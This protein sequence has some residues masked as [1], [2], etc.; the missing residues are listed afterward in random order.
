MC[1]WP[2]GLGLL[3]RGEGNCRCWLSV[4]PDRW[5]H[6][7]VGGSRTVQSRPL[8]PL[9]A[10]TKAGTLKVGSC[11]MTRASS[12]I[13]RLGRSAA[14]RPA[15]WMRRELVRTGGDVLGSTPACATDSGGRG[16]NAPPLRPARRKQHTHPYQPEQGFGPRFPRGS[17]GSVGEIA[18]TSPVGRLTEHPSDSRET[19]RPGGRP[20]QRSVERHRPG[21]P[22][23]LDLKSLRCRLGA[24]M[25]PP[26]AAARI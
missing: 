5:G 10:R 12:P 2:A 21:S 15:A 24:A 3:T 23:R 13:R 25:M 19:S 11:L 9:G 20:T 14:A 6:Q 18:R 22:S 7:R 8:D 16:R 26:A 4:Q 1:P 17:M